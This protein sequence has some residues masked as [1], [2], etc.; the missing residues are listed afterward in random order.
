MRL[1]F[2]NR[3]ES[4]KLIKK[5]GKVPF[6]EHMTITSSRLVELPDSA[7]V[8]DDLKRELTFYNMT[9]EESKKGVEF[10]LQSKVKI[11]RPEDYFAEM[12]KTDIQMSRI[13]NKIIGQQVKM[14]NFSEKKQRKDNKRFE[15]TIKT[16]RMKQKHTEKRENLDQVKKL[17]KDLKSMGDESLDVEDYLK[18]KNKKKRNVIELLKSE[19]RKKAEQKKQANSIK[20]GRLGKR[21]ITRNRKH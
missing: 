14:K 15:K 19:A 3:L 4:K 21:R 12:F 5:E 6:V 1:G 16:L 17:K 18:N 11:G 10:L 8:H 7:E 2:Y 13:K 9:L 20:K